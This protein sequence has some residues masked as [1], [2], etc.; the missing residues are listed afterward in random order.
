MC[1]KRP[2]I[3]SVALSL[4]AAMVTPGRETETAVEVGTLTMAKTN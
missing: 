2:T 1:E 4:S 3:L